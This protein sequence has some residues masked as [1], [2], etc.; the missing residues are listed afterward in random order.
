MQKKTDTLKTLDRLFK[1]N[2]AEYRRR[3]FERNCRYLEW[4]VEMERLDAENEK[5]DRGPRPRAEES[6]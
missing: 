6:A 4:L 1:E 5:K 3:E 2:M